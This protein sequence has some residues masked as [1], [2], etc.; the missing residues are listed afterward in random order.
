MPLTGA[1]YQ[2]PLFGMPQ[3]WVSVS[4]F[5]AGNRPVSVFHSRVGKFLYSF[6]LLS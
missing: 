2:Q 4:G 6:N 1:E 5:R 3:F